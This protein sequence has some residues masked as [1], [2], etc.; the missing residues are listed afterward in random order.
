MEQLKCCNIA[1]IFT[2]S[3]IIIPSPPLSSSDLQTVLSQSWA[4]PVSFLCELQGH[5][6]VCGAVHSHAKLVAFM[7]FAAHRKT[8]PAARPL[9]FTSYLNDDA[10][11]SLSLLHFCPSDTLALNT[12]RLHPRNVLAL[13]QLLARRARQR[14]ESLLIFSYLFGHSLAEIQTVVPIGPENKHPKRRSSV[15]IINITPPPGRVVS[16][17]YM[18]VRL[19]R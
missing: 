14:L 1:R 7:R 12:E 15:L 8:Y 5:I 10:Q 2:Y 3:S 18:K 17:F 6:N 4:T 9:S 16:S 11:F 13:H 19:A